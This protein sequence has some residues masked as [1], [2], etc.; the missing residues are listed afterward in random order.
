MSTPQERWTA[1][2][3]ALQQ[4]TPSD[5]FRIW[6]N[7]IEFFSYEEPNLH[8][9]VPNDYFREEFSKHYAKD[10]YRV[11]VRFFGRE[12]QVF[13]QNRK[14]IDEAAQQQKEEEA[15][16]RRATERPSIDSRLP[17]DYLL[18]NF[19]AGVSNKTAY[20][21][22]K[23]IISQPGALAFNPFFVFGASG[24]GKTHL[25]AAIGHEVV[26]KSPMK[27]V[28]FVS[29][30]DFQEQFTNASRTGKQ[31]DF[32]AFYQTIDLLILDD[33]QELTT[34]KTQ[35]TFFHIFNH[36]RQLGRQIVFTCDRRP[37]EIEGLQDR[38]LSRLQSGVIVEIERPDIQLRKDILFAR[39]RRDEIDGVGKDVVTYVAERIS[40]N[41]RELHGVLNSLMAYAVANDGEI[42]LPLMER[43]VSRY[44][45]MAEEEV[46]L[47]DIIAAV[48]KKHGLRRADLRS[49]SRK[50]EIVCA[51]QIA[52]YLCHKREMS[53][54]YIGK[55][56]GKRD[57]S[58]VSYSCDQVKHFLQTDREYRR[59]VE[60]LEASL[61]CSR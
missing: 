8:I 27:R 57:H 25:A 44:I 50:K 35:K 36:L 39:I 18:Q 32:L 17:A 58:T 7:E 46:T 20:S 38:V 6:Y 14:R 9:S 53:Y 12:V 5:I 49:K 56:F 47:D 4:E 43:I 60:E 54:S 30:R 33:V 10:F 19:V 51:R 52:M 24:V 28:L 48:A 15:A 3:E 45:S 34:E 1:F 55:E 2:R 42:T 11:L 13:V 59:Q 37:N 29:A 21:M 26:K 40:S 22:A 41:V 31:N 23:A 16:A 61:K